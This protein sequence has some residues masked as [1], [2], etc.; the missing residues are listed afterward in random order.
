MNYCVTFRPINDNN[1]KEP[2]W[3]SVLFF[4]SFFLIL[5]KTSGTPFKLYVMVSLH[6]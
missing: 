4:S 6:I 5:N 2:Y 1:Q 3:Y